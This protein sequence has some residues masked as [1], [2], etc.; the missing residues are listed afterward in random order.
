MRF[1]EFIDFEYYALIGAETKEKAINYYRE[2]VADI[3]E[4]DGEP[5]EIA[6]ANVIKK[7]LDTCKDENQKQETIKEF[8]S[9][10]SQNEPYLILIEGD[11]L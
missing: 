11:L 9:C 6:K 5:V 8:N 4:D 3:A 10:T 7:L 1:F 2:V